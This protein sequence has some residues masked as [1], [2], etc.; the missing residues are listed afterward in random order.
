MKKNIYLMY[1]IGL[2]Q[3]MVFYGP[4]ATLYRQAQGVTVFQITLIESISLALCIALEV[5]WG[6]VADRIG[7]RKTMI[8]CCLLYFVSKILF[9]QATD[10]WWFLAERILLSVVIAGMSGVD[11]SILYLSC[12][13]QNSQ[14]VF[15]IY[16]GMGMAGLL[17]AA[18]VFSLVVRDNYPLAACLTVISYAL[19]AVLALGLT[20]VKQETSPSITVSCARRCPRAAWCCFYWR[21]PSWQRP[22]R[23]SRFSS[24]SCNI[25]AAAWGKGPWAG[26]I[27]WPLSWDWRNFLCRCHKTHRN[28]WKLPALCG[29]VHRGL[30]GAGMDPE[31]SRFSGKYSAAAAVQHP[32]SALPGPNAEPA[33]SDR[34]PGNG[35]ERQCHADGL[36][37]RGQQSGLWCLVGILPDIGLCL[38][39][40]PQ[41]SRAAFAAGL[42][43]KDCSRIMEGHCPA[44]KRQGN[45]C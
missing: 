23:P 36:R 45:F 41:R 34:K 43:S 11:S 26:H 35:P 25:S 12:Q 28:L 31:R 39:R 16:S 30:P 14:K 32:V 6:V 2:L 38:W 13:G 7:Y 9:W 44:G 1:A 29:I 22:T 5:P 37:C 33:D 42:V 20:E 40:Y 4:I 15:G 17:I 21:R 19:A 27:S 18:G 24:T 10:F 8:F 3:G